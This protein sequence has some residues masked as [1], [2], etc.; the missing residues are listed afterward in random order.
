MT[1]QSSAYW[2][3]QEFFQ[4]LG[5][6]F[7]LELSNLIRDFALEGYGPQDIDLLMP[8][9]EQTTAFKN[10]FAGYHQRV[11]NG[12]NAI[13]IYEYRQL[14]NEYHRIMAEAGLP[15][16]FYDDPSDYANFIA[17]NV[18]VAEIQSRVDMAVKAAQSVDPTARDLMARFYG[19]GTGDVAA[20]FLDQSRA[21]PVI[22]R[23]YKAANVASWA[24][25]V[26]FGVGAMDRYEALVD[27]GVTEEQAAQSYGTIKS[28]S[29]SVGGIAGVYGETYSQTD[30]EDDVFFGKSEKRR[31]LVSQEE[32]T[33]R[34][35]SEGATGSARRQ[36]Y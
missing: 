23:Q 32:A 28:L 20:Y 13:S 30:A 36:S 27:Y 31:K 3:L 14:E 11:A 34:G 26:G 22:E 15:V 10:R 2:I 25:R 24:Q 16:G 5:L 12:Y 4:S 9:L 17:N 7:D 1:T 33:F 18:S 35:R 6:V 19:L 8:Q 21:L 29:D